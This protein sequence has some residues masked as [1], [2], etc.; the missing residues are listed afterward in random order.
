MKTS[1]E[2]W[3][4]LKPRKKEFEFS[5]IFDFDAKKSNETEETLEEPAT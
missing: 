4:A 3:P 2:S 5:I 1:H